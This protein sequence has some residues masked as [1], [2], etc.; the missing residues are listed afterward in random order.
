MNTG[1]ESPAFRTIS[2]A[3]RV[4]VY[5]VDDPSLLEGVDDDGSKWF[6]PP[7]SRGQ[8]H[9]IP[10]FNRPGME[11]ARKLVEQEL[12]RDPSL[13]YDWGF[14]D[15]EGLGI[16]PQFRTI[17]ANTQPVFRTIFRRH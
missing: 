5:R 7:V 3:S 9:Q 2:R 8:T 14:Y 4:K 6:D 16:K 12:A 11:E 13:V 17:R 15:R 10:F 1:P